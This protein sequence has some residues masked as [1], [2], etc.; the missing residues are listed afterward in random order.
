VKISDT[1][2]GIPQEDIDKI[3]DPGFTTKGVGVGMG[4]GLSITYNIVQKHKGEIEVES[5][6][7]K[8]STFTVR[9]PVA[10]CCEQ[11]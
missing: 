6:V 11:S 2:K 3:F 1:G 7:G 10:G 4:L 8:G 5:E 9:I